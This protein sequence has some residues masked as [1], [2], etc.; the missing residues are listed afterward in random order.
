MLKGVGSPSSSAKTHVWPYATALFRLRRVWQD[1]GGAVAQA[2]SQLCW[3]ERDV[4]VI[5][6][7][8][9]SCENS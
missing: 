1:G 2:V 7:V 8:V 9:K 6:K 4:D 3:R 5:L